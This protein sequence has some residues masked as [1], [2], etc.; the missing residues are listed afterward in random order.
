MKIFAKVLI[1]HN[2]KTPLWFDKHQ[3]RT[4]LALA[5]YCHLYQPWNQSSQNSHH[6]YSQKK[7][8]QTTQALVQNFVVLPESVRFAMSYRDA[9]VGKKEIQ[10]ILHPSFWTLGLY[11]D[12]VLR[13]GYSNTAFYTFSHPRA[14]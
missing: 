14:L 8:Q 12:E 3:S 9:Q 1:F 7:S 2:T 4:I 6:L 5:T 10:S 11:I 13:P